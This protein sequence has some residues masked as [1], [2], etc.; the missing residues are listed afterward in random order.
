MAEDYK[1]LQ[2][3][4]NVNSDITPITRKPIDQI[5]SSEWD[6]LTTRELVDQRVALQQRMMLI[7]TMG[8]ADLMAE[9]KRGLTR[10]DLI[11]KE[12]GENEDTH[13]I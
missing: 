9:M 13:L 1:D 6:Q 7:Q 11:L 4:V 12:R 10:L 3:P 8:R 5:D 2:G